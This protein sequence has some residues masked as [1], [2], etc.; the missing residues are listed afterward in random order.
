MLRVLLSRIV[1]MFRSHQ[2]DEE[3]D[4]EFRAH[5]DMLEERFVR[6]GMEP[7]E[8]RSAARR[9]FGGVTQVK[10]HL[11]ER[12]ALPL[13]DVLMLDLRHALRRLQGSKRFTASAALTLALGIGATTSVFGALDSVVLKPL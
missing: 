5:L 8:A 10:E 12:R 11:R 3:L 7:T 13:F 6:R 4:E 2:L 1:G 9:Q